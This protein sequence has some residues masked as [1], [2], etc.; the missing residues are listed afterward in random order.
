MS[1]R[2][3]EECDPTQVVSLTILCDE[4]RLIRT[5]CTEEA[6]KLEFTLKVQRLRNLKH[7]FDNEHNCL[8]DM[9]Q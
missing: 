4:Y 2:E 3:V 6:V 8:Q 5:E 7:L 1:W 9:K